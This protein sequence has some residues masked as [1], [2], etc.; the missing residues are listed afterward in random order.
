MMK[1]RDQKVDPMKSPRLITIVAL[2]CG[3]V[4]ETAAEEVERTYRTNIFGLLHS[5][6][7]RN[8]TMD[9]K[10]YRINNGSLNKPIT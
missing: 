3:A 4:E 7:E 10:L 9:K 2:S 1:A 8:K 6:L 5:S